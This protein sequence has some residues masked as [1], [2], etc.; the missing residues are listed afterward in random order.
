MSGL[1]HLM[2]DGS[3]EGE[4]AAAGGQER[5]VEAVSGA[6]RFVVKAQRPA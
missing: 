4:Q 5:F 2:L 6:V 1:A 3:L